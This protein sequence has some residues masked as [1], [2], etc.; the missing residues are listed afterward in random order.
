MTSTS[1]NFAA[2]AAATQPLMRTVFF[3]VGASVAISDVL[4][5]LRDRL[6]LFGLPA[7]EPLRDRERR[8]HADDAGVEIQLGHALEAAG[9][10][11]LDAHAASLAVI[12][13]DLVQAV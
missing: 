8:V 6:Q 13:Q 3:F 5:P 1:A 7:V 12:H 4:G 10:A 2:C 9:R 11:L